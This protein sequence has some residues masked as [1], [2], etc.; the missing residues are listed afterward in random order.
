[1]WLL[2]EH[3]SLKLLSQVGLVVHSYTPNTWEVKAGDLPWA[4]GQCM[5]SDT[6]S[7]KF[8]FN[9]ALNDF[10]WN[11]CVVVGMRSVLHCL[12]LWT[13]SPRLMAGFEEIQWTQSRWR[14]EVYQWGR[15][16][17][18]T[19]SC[20]H[21]VPPP[22]HSL[23][24]LAVQD[25][26]ISSLLQPLCL[27]LSDGLYLSGTRSPHELFPHKLPWSGCFTSETAK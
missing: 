24:L 14:K 9:T 15:L 3:C 1:M 27:L 22:V 21:S 7:K 26:S 10:C 8:F 12:D 6:V 23:P 17:E 13:L 4:L 19:L 25:V 2:A 5:Q 18:W 20:F 11:E 16:W